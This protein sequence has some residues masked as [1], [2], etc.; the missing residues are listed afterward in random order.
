MIFYQ[1]ASCQTELTTND[2]KINMR[3]CDLNTPLSENCFCPG[4]YIYNFD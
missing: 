2:L 4:E 3:L 1:D